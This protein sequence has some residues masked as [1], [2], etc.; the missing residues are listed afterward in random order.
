MHPL[1]KAPAE[2]TLVTQ[3]NHPQD[4]ALLAHSAVL[5]TFKV[6]KQALRCVAELVTLSIEKHPAAKRRGAVGPRILHCQGTVTSIPLAGMSVTVLITIAIS[7]FFCTLGIQTPQ[8]LL[9]GMYQLF[10][11][12]ALGVIRALTI[13]V[14]R[15][16]TRVAAPTILAGGTGTACVGLAFLSHSQP[17]AVASRTRRCLDALLTL[18]AFYLPASTVAA[19]LTFCPGITLGGKQENGQAQYLF[20]SVLRGGGKVPHTI[21]FSTVIFLWY[22]WIPVDKPKDMCTVCLRTQFLALKRTTSTNT[23]LVKLM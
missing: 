21:S 12:A 8:R 14:R 19:E 17:W 22:L 2:D 20:F 13:I 4:Q 7:R 10:T 3:R 23:G 15:L 6:V 16:R 5:L 9:A 1:L 11:L 18:L